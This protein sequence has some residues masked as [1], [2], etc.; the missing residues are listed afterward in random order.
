MNILISNDDG[1]A[2]NG[3]R[4]LTEELSKKHDV[5]VVAPDRERSAAGHSLTLHTPLR[6][7]EVDGSKTGAKRTWVT[8]GTP[9]D[10]VKIAINAI[11]TKEEMPDIVISGINHG[12][13]LGADILY[14]GTVS[15]AMEGAM[16]GFPAIAVSLASMQMEYEDFKFSAHFTSVLLDKLQNFKFPSKCILNVNV[17]LLNSEDI[18]GVAITELGKK[19]FTDDYE[20]RVDPRGKVYYWMAGKLIKE[21]LDAKTDIAAVMSN[22]ISITPVT[23]EMT[24]TETIEDLNKILCSGNSCQWY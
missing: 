2:A 19:M 8:S 6:V 9:G 23:Y 11:L 17:P 21:N 22:K 7:E 20:K 14:S 12:P 15:C 24:R 5:Y 1:I 16:L 3:I 18:T 13:N 10:C 4:A